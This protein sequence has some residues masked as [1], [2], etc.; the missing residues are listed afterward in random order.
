MQLIKIHLASKKKEG[1]N[2]SNLHPCQNQMRLG[3]YYP[4]VD[5]SSHHQHYGIV[6]SN[7]STYL[8]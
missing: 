3:L 6:Y 1:K 7:L 5:T 4:H 8:V 2:E